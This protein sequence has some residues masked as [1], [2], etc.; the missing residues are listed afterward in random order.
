MAIGSTSDDLDQSW[1][2]H[3]YLD[4]NLGLQFISYKPLEPREREPRQPHKAYC[5]LLGTTRPY[6]SG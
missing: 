5:G 2:C 3:A 6:W 4:P 1:T